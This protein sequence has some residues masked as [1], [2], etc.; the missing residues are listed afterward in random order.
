MGEIKTNGMQTMLRMFAKHGPQASLRQIMTAPNEFT[1]MIGTADSIA[2]HMRDTMQ[3]VGG[4]G[5]L[6]AGHFKP[7][8]VTSIVDELVPVL[9]KR[10]LM[11]TGYDHQLFRDNLLAF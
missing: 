5:F 3:E 8:Y 2:E 6:I 10:G 4:D 11:R 7:K 9:Q 1:S